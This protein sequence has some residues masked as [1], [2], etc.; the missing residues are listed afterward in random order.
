MTICRECDG[1]GRRQRKPT[2]VDPL[3]TAARL[4]HLRSQLGVR[5]VTSPSAAQTTVVQIEAGKPHTAHLE[6]AKLLQSLTGEIRICDP[7]YGT[8]SLYRLAELANAASVR[9]LTHKPD[10]KE[11]P[12]LPKAKKDFVT[13]RP[14]VEFREHVGNELHDRY[15]VAADELVLLGHGLKDIGG[16]ESFVVRL[17][18][19]LA[20][21]T[22]DALRESF[23][24]KWQAA[25]PLP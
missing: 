6:V 24:Q 5:D 7:Y 14:T 1:W 23:D 13:E 19:A 4:E 11:K 16:K 18:R 2:A 15:V 12:F 21:D 3:V 25:K 10:G 20:G 17:D 9:F 22:I 8:G